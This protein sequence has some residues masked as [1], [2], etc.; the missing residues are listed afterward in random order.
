MM[1][2]RIAE[3]EKDNLIGLGNPVGALCSSHLL[4]LQFFQ[5]K[6]PEK[7]GST[8]NSTIRSDV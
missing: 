1:T 2:R 6:G 5:N 3:K 7:S 8:E 4:R